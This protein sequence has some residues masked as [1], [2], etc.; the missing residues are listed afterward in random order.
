MTAL[1]VVQAFAQAELGFSKEV[2]RK[3]GEQHYKLSEICAVPKQR[4]TGVRDP[5]YM[6]V[7]VLLS[8]QPFRHDSREASTLVLD[9]HVNICSSF[10]VYR[11]FV[12]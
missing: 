10:C 2:R 3:F 12:K 11:C 6:Q 8:A 9:R 5:N 1:Q 7:L 4:C